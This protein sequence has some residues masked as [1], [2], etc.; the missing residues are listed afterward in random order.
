ME[1]F[2][3]VPRE[4]FDPNQVYRPLPT[5][6][7]PTNVPFVV[8]NLWEY[9]RPEGQ[10]SRRH[11]LYASPSPELALQNASAGGPVR[12]NYVVCKLRV[13][14]EGGETSA[15]HD[16]AGYRVAQLAVSDARDHSDIFVL[17]KLVL[18]SLGAGFPEL[19][20]HEKLES[21][22]LFLPGTSREELAEAGERNPKIAEILKNARSLSS[23]WPEARAPMSTS[24]G[25][26]FF[27]LL[28]G[29]A[30]QL[31]PVSP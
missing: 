22:A 23:F 3:A 26:L 6:R 8:D 5:R 21:A 17:K 15:V 4:R 20:L 2:R 11:A 9:L 19:P 16:A 24:N 18:A 13:F 1:L 31:E 14:R 25:E 29:Y 30:Y 10:P 7:T 27:E 12:E 28:P